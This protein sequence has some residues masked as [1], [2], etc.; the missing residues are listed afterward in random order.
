MVITQSSFIIDILVNLEDILFVLYFA[1]SPVSSPP[2]PTPGFDMLVFCHLAEGSFLDKFFKTTSSMDPM[3][4]ISFGFIAISG[5][6]HPSSYPMLMCSSIICSVPCSLRTMGKWRL[7][8]WW[9][10]LLV[11]LRSALKSLCL[12]CI[13]QIDSPYPKSMPNPETRHFYAIR[14]HLGLCFAKKLLKFI[15]PNLS[16]EL[17][18]LI[19]FTLPF[20]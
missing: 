11:K 12:S 5:Q 18:F 2:N 20:G 19:D 6:S 14:Y 1:C 7:L 15:I 17:Q 4:V 16:L 9:Q 10:L 3:Q 8:I 13:S